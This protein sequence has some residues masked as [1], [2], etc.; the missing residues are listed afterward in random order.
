M[1]IIFSSTIQCIRRS[2]EV[3]PIFKVGWS[4]SK[5]VAPSCRHYFFSHSRYCNYYKIADL[6]KNNQR[7]ARKSKKKIGLETGRPKR[8]YKISDTEFPEVFHLWSPSYPLEEVVCFDK[9]CVCIKKILS[10][11]LVCFGFLQF[12]VH[13][14]HSLTSLQ[15][16]QP[17]VCAQNPCSLQVLSLCWLLFCWNLICY[18]LAHYQ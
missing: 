10:L 12:V 3:C 18:H 15:E 8:T 9:I 14:N 16:L 2:N 1:A 4:L 17:L 6:E 13:C 7:W 11:W 5:K